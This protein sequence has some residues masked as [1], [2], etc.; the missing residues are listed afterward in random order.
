MPKKERFSFS[1]AVA[2]PVVTAT[3][4][5]SKVKSP[6]LLTACNKLLYLGTMVSRHIRCSLYFSEELF[7][8]LQMSENFFS[9]Y[10][11][12]TG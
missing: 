5:I 9:E 3:R 7:V 4:T 10:D 1:S 6:P 2:L 11:P 8:A 12:P